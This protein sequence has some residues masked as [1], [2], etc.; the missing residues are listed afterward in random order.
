MTPYLKF[1]LGVREAI[2]VCYEKGINPR[3]LTIGTKQFA[4]LHDEDPRVYQEGCANMVFMGMDIRL[5]DASNL[6]RVDEVEVQVLFI[7]PKAKDDT[8]IGLFD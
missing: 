2:E 7:A 1:Y 3:V 6:I 5:D 4:V 8:Q